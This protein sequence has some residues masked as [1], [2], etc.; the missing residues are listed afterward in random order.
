[1]VEPYDEHYGMFKLT[2]KV[3]EVE[4][5]LDTTLDASPVSIAVPS[6]SLPSPLELLEQWQ[7]E[8]TDVDGAPWSLTRWDNVLSMPLAV[9]SWGSRGGAR[10]SRRRSLVKHTNIRMHLR[11]PPARNVARLALAATRRDEF[12]PSPHPVMRRLTCDG[13]AADPALAHVLHL[14]ASLSRDGDD[15]K[16]ENMCGYVHVRE[17]GDFASLVNDVRSAELADAAMEERAT[18]DGTDVST[19]QEVAAGAPTKSWGIL[20]MACH[21]IER[22]RKKTHA[23]ARVVMQP[24]A[25]PRGCPQKAEQVRVAVRA[26]RDAS[27]AL[28]NRLKSLG[29]R[30]KLEEILR[31]EVV[32]GLNAVVVDVSEQRVQE[33]QQVQEQEQRRGES[34]GRELASGKKRLADGALKMYEK[35][36]TA[37]VGTLSLSP[38]RFFGADITNADNASSPSYSFAASAVGGT[39]HYD[40]QKRHSPQDRLQLM[41]SPIGTVMSTTGTPIHGHAK[42]PR[43]MS[44]QIMKRMRA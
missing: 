23:L 43:I 10:A 6:P 25:Q 19:T 40:L 26:A 28:G 41:H 2:V 12:Y 15:S 42:T 18:E 11:Q 24:P 8:D 37:A 27:L 39:P 14:G 29:G 34:S 5:G 33:Q 36:A 9:L 31:D 17:V 38:G 3:R 20:G 7:R 35:R 1:M 21:A 4:G 44:Q 16:R 32:E 13:P 30:E 22:A